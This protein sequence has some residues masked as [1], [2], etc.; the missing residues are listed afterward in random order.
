MKKEAPFE[1]F[2]EVNPPPPPPPNLDKENHEDL[3]QRRERISIMV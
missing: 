2:F 3:Q 1:V